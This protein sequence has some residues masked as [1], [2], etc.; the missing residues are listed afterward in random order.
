MKKLSLAA[1][2]AAAALAGPALAN[3]TEENCKAYAE[4]N[5][6]DASGCPCLGEA[7]DA[8]PALASALAAISSPEELEAASDETKAAIAACFPEA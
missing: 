6:S 1:F 4:A 2:I 3:E 7:A 8:D 5:G